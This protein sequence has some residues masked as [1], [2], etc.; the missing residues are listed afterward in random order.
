MGRGARGT[1]DGGRPSWRGVPGSSG[2]RGGRESRR[3]LST[4]P[5]VHRSKRSD[6][7]ED[8]ERPSVRDAARRIQDSALDPIDLIGAFWA[9]T[10][11][12]WQRSP[13]FVRAPLQAVTRT[14]QA[15]FQDSCH[16]YAAAIAYYAIFSLIP[17]A[18]ITVALLGLLVPEEDVVDFIYS[19][20]PVEESE[21]LSSNLREVVSLTANVSVTVLVIGVV[22]LGWSA[23]GVFSAIRQG[24]N[25]ASH[26]KTRHSFLR[27]KLIDL[28]VVPAFGA[29]LFAG[30]LLNGFTQ[31]V[32][33]Q[34]VDW[35]PVNQ[36]QEV[37]RGMD[38]Y[39]I[40]GSLSFVF[41]LLVYRLV[42]SSRPG[43]KEAAVAAICATL[44][45]ELVRL[46]A[47][48]LLNYMPWTRATALYS[49]LATAL[50][51][52]YVL[53]IL[54]AIILVGA[55]FGRIVVRWQDERERLIEGSR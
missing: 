33:D 10:L 37:L 31:Y 22:A 28:A 7:R 9:V 5:D 46:G 13:G 43:W 38:S 18:I 21:E 12:G 55:E 48:Q 49:G 27:G 23:S 53:R 32:L 25:A 54:G 34:S 44:L 17:L 1:I 8:P 51:V 14:L 39:A 2:L 35:R 29:L 4:E 40:A 20:G 36:F 26:H 6:E 3:G 41:F 52:L 24:L 30:L 16:I 45:F 47:A 19:L 15:Y 50:A 42:P 11:A